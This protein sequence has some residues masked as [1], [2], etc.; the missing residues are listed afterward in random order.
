MSSA[1]TLHR[2]TVGKKALVAITGLVLFGFVIGHLA[3]NLILFAGYEAFNG[4]AHTLKSTLPL[5]WGTRITLLVSVIVHIALTM[6][7]AGRNTAARGSRY[8]KKKDQVTSYAART[9]VLSGPLLAGFI[10]FHLAHFTV[11]GLDLGGEHEAVNAYGNLVRGFRVPW[12]AGIYIFANAMLGLHLFHGAW[13]ALQSVGAGHP[14][15]NPM[16]KTA[17]MGLALAISAGNIFI[18]ISV[19]TGITGS[20]EQLQLSD[21]HPLGPDVA[22]ESEAE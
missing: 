20:D 16:R 5:L 2:S 14:K 15:Y 13:S 4:Y 17:A 6:S 18:P 8:K 9:M 7:L 19:L 22:V 10:L 12:V 1:L 3:G 11:P 21:Q